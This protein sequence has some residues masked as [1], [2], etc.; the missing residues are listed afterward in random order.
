M[1]DRVAQLEARVAELETE[2]EIRDRGLRG[3]LTH[4]FALL[5]RLLHE[6]GVLDA[7]DVRSGLKGLFAPNPQ[8]DEEEG[9]VLHEIYQALALQQREEVIRE[10]RGSIG[11]AKGQA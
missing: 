2:L 6:R 10:L 3:A 5:V 9:Q 7:Q 8:D 1:T 4:S 11:N